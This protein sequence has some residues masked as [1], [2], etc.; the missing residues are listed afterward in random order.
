[1]KKNKT[2]ELLAFLKE[3]PEDPFLKYALALEYVKSGNLHE[4]FFYLNTILEDQPGYLAAYYQLGKVLE[5]LGRTDEAINT[6]STGMDTAKA[7]NKKHTYS[8]LEQAYKL[9]SGNED[10]DD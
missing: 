10:D 1:M 2:D 4:A 8:E 5:A 9:A 6:Y 3:E 7:Q